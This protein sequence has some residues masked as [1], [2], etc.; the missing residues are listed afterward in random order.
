[1]FNQSINIKPAKLYYAGNDLGLTFSEDKISYKIWSPP[2]QSAFFEI[3][4]DDQGS[5]KLDE[6]ELQS[7]FSDT[8]QVEL[9]QKYYGKYYRLRLRLPRKEYNFVDPWA[10]AVGT[11]SEYGLIV[12]P[13]RIYPPSWTHDQKVK[14]ED[15]VDAVIYELHVKDFSASRESGIRQKGKYTAFTEKHSVN[16]EGMLT[17]I[18]HL[19]ELGVTHVHLLPVYDF[20]SVDDNDPDDYNW[21]YDPLYYMFP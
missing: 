5:K 14:L 16:K 1:M 12:D 20:A 21:G 15:P 2:A 11:N 13:S 17:G 9:P 3:Y 10:K 7:A 4:A 18:A 8:W 19:Q 6:Y